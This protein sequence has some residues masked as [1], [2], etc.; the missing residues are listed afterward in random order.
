[1]KGQH[2]ASVDC[3][4]AALSTGII[5]ILQF[6]NQRKTV[7]K[8]EQ[9]AAERRG[10]NFHENFVCSLKI[11]SAMLKTNAANKNTS[12]KTALFALGMG[13][14]PLLNPWMFLLVQDSFQASRG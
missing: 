14:R 3:D 10:R 5:A 2:P 11:D 8:T 7:A 13:T 4:H 12:T 9:F 6:Y 1:M